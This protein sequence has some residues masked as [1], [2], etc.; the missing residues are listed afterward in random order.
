MK[1][2][3]SR[4]IFFRCYWFLLNCFQTF[5]IVTII[6]CSL[7]LTFFS[8]SVVSLSLRH[9]LV[10][11]TKVEFDDRAKMERIRSDKI[12]NGFDIFCDE[13]ITLSP[14]RDATRG[15]CGQLGKR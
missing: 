10:S 11:M 13:I 6:S 8:G 4:V 3:D 1:M 9:V 15:S 14:L 2:G 12:W 7:R 5:F